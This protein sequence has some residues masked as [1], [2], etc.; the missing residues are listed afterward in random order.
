M[1]PKRK[2][3]IRMD[4][5]TMIDI[6]DKFPFIDDLL[7][8]LSILDDDDDETIQFKLELYLLIKPLLFA[9]PKKIEDKQ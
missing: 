8:S 1:I 9:I 3:G 6:R 5:K 7:F 4:Y 2:G